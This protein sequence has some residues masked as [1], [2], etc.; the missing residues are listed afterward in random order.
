MLCVPL[1]KQPPE[2][3]DLYQFPFIEKMS[4]SR[5]IKSFGG[6]TDIPFQYPISTVI[7]LKRL[8]HAINPEGGYDDHWIVTQEL[9]VIKNE[10]E[11]V[12]EITI[13][14]IKQLGFMPYTDIGMA[15]NPQFRDW[16]NSRYA[17]PRYRKATD[18]YECWNWDN[19]IEFDDKYYDFSEIRENIFEYWKGK[20]LTIHCN[21][22]C[23]ILTREVV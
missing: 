5:F 22:Y 8:I 20:P 6:Y 13:D 11:R 4:Y 15:K 23:E 12:Q 3:Y 1:R 18:S 9:K 19:T 2:G 16:F 21:P 7:G 10:V 14:E 17:K